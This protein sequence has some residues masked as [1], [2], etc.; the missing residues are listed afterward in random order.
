M[1]GLRKGF[2]NPDDTREP[3]VGQTVQHPM[4]RRSFIFRSSAALAGFA[5]LR[6]ALS[7]A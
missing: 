1:R 5:G 4:N 2:A 3:N 6:P 7:V